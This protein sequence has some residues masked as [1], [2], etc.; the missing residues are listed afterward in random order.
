MEAAPTVALPV[1][2]AAPAGAKALETVHEFVLARLSAPVALEDL[3]RA[4][5]SARARSTP[6]STGI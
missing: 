3:A 2:A 4:A 5:G 1:V 6:R